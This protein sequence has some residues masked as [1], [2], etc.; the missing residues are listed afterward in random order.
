MNYVET[1]L[2]GYSNYAGYLFKAIKSP[3]L[4]NYF[5]W[6]IGVSLVFFILEVVIP[7]RKNQKTIRKD[8]WLDAFYMFFNFIFQCGAFS[9][10][11]SS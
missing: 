9:L 3:H 11:V 7:W 1:F 8:F 2:N 5:Y 10:L 4:N 6:L